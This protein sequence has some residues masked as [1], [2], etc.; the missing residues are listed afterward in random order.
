MSR[1]GLGRRIGNAFLLQA[2]AIS[3]ASAL[4]VFLSGLVLEEVLIKEALRQEAVYFWERYAR[5]PDFPVPDTRNLT[6]FLDAGTTGIGPDAALMNLGPGFH[7]LPTQVDFSM[8]YVTEQDGH[9]LYLVFDGARVNELATYFG[10]VPLA[11]VLTA[12]YLSAWLAYRAAHRAVSPVTWLAEEVD[13]LDPRAP[14]PTLFREERLPSEADQ[15]VLVLANALTH[16]AERLNAFVERERNFT[17]DASHELRSPLT[18][19]RIA[20]D[21]LGSE[22]ELSA[23]ALSSVNRIRRAISDME[24]LV[25]V[26][27]LLARESDRGLATESVC[28]NDVIAEELERVRLTGAADKPVEIGLHEETRL[29][30]NASDKVLSVLIGNV[31]RNAFSYTDAGRVDISVRSAEVVIEDSGIGMPKEQVEHAFDPFYRGQPSRRG[32]HGV[33]LSIVKRLSDRFGWPVRIDSQPGV[34]TRVTVSFPATPV[35]P[36]RQAVAQD[37]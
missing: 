17:R 23:P 19:I 30:V 18:V 31:L 3:V 14:D 7:S 10:L 16:F 26:F 34:G 21:M 5:D 4:G 32:G 2:A 11:L 15:E 6:G 35:E 9:R 20:A 13:R 29:R 12:L 8:A 25:E 24:E 33:G 27:L 37:A 1:P 22:Q 28:V 36:R